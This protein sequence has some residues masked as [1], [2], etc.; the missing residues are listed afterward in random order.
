MFKK[1][2]LEDVYGTPQFPVLKEEISSLTNQRYLKKIALASKCY[3][4]RQTAV[5]RLDDQKLLFRIAQKN[6][7]IDARIDALKRITDTGKGSL[8][9][10]LSSMTAV[11]QI[12]TGL[13]RSDR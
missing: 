8:L 11:F 12:T 3:E 4:F 1:S 13:R 2:W 9:H 7:S 5:C 10:Y 6:E